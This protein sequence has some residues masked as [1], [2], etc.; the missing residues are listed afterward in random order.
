MFSA[1][2][3]LLAGAGL[4]ATLGAV[5]DWKAELAPVGD[6]GIAGSATVQ[7]ALPSMA[8]TTMPAKAEFT[9]EVSI[10]GGTDGNKHPWHV[11]SGTCGTESAPIVGD[12]SAYSPITIES[13]GE[14]KATA[15]VNAEISP[16]GQYLV[17]IHR[18]PDDLTVI[19]CG[20]LK[21]T[22]VTP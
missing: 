16:N 20:E 2:L 21:A 11:H 15:T 9:A 10:R 1:A 3:K 19:S 12:A 6:S 17:N 14:G 18:S 7:T 4:V 8:D 22:G 13:S 5:A